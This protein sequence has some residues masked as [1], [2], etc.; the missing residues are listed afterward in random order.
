MAFTLIQRAPRDTD[1]RLERICT[2]VGLGCSSELEDAVGCG[3]LSRGRS[4]SRRLVNK[5]ST[6]GEDLELLQPLY[7]GTL[8]S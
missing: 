5:S 1:G 8:I 3:G 2:G 6:A 7:Y 4:S